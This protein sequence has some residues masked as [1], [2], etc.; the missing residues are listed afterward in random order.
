M[1]TELIKAPIRGGLSCTMVLCPVRRHGEYLGRGT[2]VHL[3][4]L[5]CAACDSAFLTFSGIRSPHVS[6]ANL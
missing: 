1:Q 3:P 6:L 5:I 2:G 4:Y